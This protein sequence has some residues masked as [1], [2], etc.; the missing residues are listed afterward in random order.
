ML[1]ETPVG[2]HIMCPSGSQ[3]LPNLKRV[4][5]YQ[6]ESPMTNMAMHG[7]VD[8]VD[9]LSWKK[10]KLYIQREQEIFLFILCFLHRALCILTYFSPRFI[11][12]EYKE[13]L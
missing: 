9:T 3:F 6:W 12:I 2:R 5:R 4:D 10:Q 8:R 13:F 1:A 11:P 7:N